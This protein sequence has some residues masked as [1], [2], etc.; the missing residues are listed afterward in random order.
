MSQPREIEAGTD[1]AMVGLWDTAVDA[2]PLSTRPSMEGW[3]TESGT[4]HLLLIHTWGDGSYRGAFY[5]DTDIPQPILDDRIPVGDWRLLH[6]PSGQLCFGGSEDYRATKKRI[7]D[8]N[9]LLEVAPG[10]YRVRVHLIDYAVPKRQLAAQ[11]G[12][13]DYAYWKGIDRVVGRWT[14]L[15]LLVLAASIALGIWQSWWIGVLTAAAALATWRI[16][17]LGRRGDPRYKAIDRRVME[18]LD[19]ETLE[20]REEKFVEGRPELAFELQRLTAGETP[21][22]AG[23]IDISIR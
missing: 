13:A 11:V 18:I 2:E 20:E 21:P 4:G 16:A 19:K 15:L 8:Q 6:A 10:D 22:Q 23:S 9:S 7:T 12:E 1:I 5:V 17:D 3:S 14:C